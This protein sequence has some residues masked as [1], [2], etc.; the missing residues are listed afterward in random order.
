MKNIYIVLSQSGSIPSRFLKFFTHDQYNHVSI[1]L[2]PTLEKMYSFARLKPNNPFIGGFVEEGKDFGTFKKFSKT[3]VNV[4]EFEVT[5]EKYNAIKYFIEYFKRNKEKFKY[6]YIGV[7]FAALK[8]NYRPKH[9]F[10]CSQFVKTILACFNIE[11]STELPKV[12][13]HIDFLKLNNKRIIYTGLF[14]RYTSVN[15]S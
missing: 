13:K 2:T 3:V 14:Q 1:S 4:M 5:D 12:V 15:K 11:N 7:F 6:N 8:L 9:K 10:Y